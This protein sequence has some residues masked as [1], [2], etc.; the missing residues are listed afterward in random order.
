[1]SY[2]CSIIRST[3]VNLIKHILQYVA[4]TLKLSSIDEWEADIP[5]NVISYTD[6][7]F[8]ECKLNQK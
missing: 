2:F 1:M 4:E 7:D 8:I 6:S 5:N 3:R